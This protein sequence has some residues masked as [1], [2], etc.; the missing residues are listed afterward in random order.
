M[1][2]TNK[3]LLYNEKCPLCD[4]K[5]CHLYW[6]SNAPKRDYYHCQQCDLIFVPTRFHLC[7]EEERKIYDLHENDPS[8]Q[9]YRNFLGKLFNPMAAL[10][11]QQC[12]GLDFGSGPGP[13]LSKMFIEHG[14]SC[15]IY[16]KFYANDANALKEDYDFVCSTEVVE[17]LAEPRKVFAMFFELTKR[18]EGPVGVMTKLHPQDFKSF[19]NWHYKNDPTHITFYSRLTMTKLAKQYH[20]ELKMIG[21]DVIMFI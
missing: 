20:R 10:L 16:D 12:K 1:D 13:T 17:H 15:A 3:S 11:S 5:T 7:S 6:Q 14:H 19:E 18:K 21:N 8:D 2:S 9:H 4:R